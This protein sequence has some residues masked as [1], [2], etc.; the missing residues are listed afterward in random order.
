MPIH[1]IHDITLDIFWEEKSPNLIL[2]WKYTLHYK[3]A[4]N[5]KKIA[6]METNLIFL[7]LSMRALNNWNKLCVS[8]L[9][10]LNSLSMTSESWAVRLTRIFLKVL[11]IWFDWIFE[12]FLKGVFQNFWIFRV[13]KV[14]C[15]L[16]VKMCKAKDD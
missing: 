13:L 6:P 3:N 12:Y 8:F 14:C 11:N 1:D 7:F 9:K 16:C 10:F 15:V 4:L 2:C 5:T